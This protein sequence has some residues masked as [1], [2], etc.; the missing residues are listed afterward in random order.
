MPGAASYN[1]IA[2][3]ITELT[4]HRPYVFVIMPFGAG[5]HLFETIRGVVQQTLNFACMNAAALEGSGRALLEKIHAWIQ[6]AEIVVAE[7]SDSDRPN[8]WPALH[9]SIRIFNKG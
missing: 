7:I 3:Q 1:T 6:R 4:G 2:D 9:L 5:G 8:I